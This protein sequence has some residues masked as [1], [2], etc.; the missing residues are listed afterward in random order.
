MQLNENQ[1]RIV[2][3]ALNNIKYG[4]HQVFE[5]SGEAG[6]GKSVV[7]Y[8]IARRSGFAMDEILPMA[9]TGQASIIMRTKGFPNAT[10][11]HSGLFQVEEVLDTSSTNF[12]TYFN[13]PEMKLRF[14]PK[15]DLGRIKA[16]FIDEGYMTPLSMKSTIESYGLP[17]IV[18]GD[19]GQLGP[20]KDKPAFLT[21]PNVPTLTQ[22]MRQSEHDPIVYLARR[23]RRGLPINTGLY[24]NKVLVI[25]ERDVTDNMLQHANMILCGKNKTREAL[26]DHIRHDIYNIKSTLPV[27]GERVICRKNNHFNIIN[28][29]NL[30]NGL[31]GNVVSIP[32]VTK[33]D[34]KTFT[35]DFLPDLLDVPFKN[36]ICDYEYY[37]TKIEDRKYNKYARGE[38]FEFAY[39]ITTHLSQ[40]A[41]AQNGIYFEEYMPQDMQNRLNYVG[42]TR[43]KNFL[44][45]VKPNRKMQFFF[46][47]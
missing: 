37:S 4:Y 2:N 10:T 34:G 3:E 8:E 9:Y 35:I 24:G 22:L 46:N 15:K 30:A 45:Y 1:E 6:T 7:L 20:V 21:D 18:G 43:F 40:G 17:I 29:I 38:Q 14:V 5:F 26:N 12:N 47:N 42:I 13:V 41:E 25:E 16:I 32:D 19:S 11:I 44:I 31:M 36:L 28:G 33:F 27:F 23:A 39:A